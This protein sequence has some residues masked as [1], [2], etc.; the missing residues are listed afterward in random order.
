M[1]V[2]KE[3]LQA[4]CQWHHLECQCPE[5]TVPLHERKMN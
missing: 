5:K 1:L 3:T 4:S 2:M